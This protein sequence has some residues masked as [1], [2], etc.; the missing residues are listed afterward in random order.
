MMF[1]WVLLLR[2]ADK[3]TEVCVFIVQTSNEEE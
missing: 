3:F 2:V 1:T